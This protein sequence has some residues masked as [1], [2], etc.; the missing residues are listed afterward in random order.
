ME[1]GLG[2]GESLTLPH[3]P[4]KGRVKKQGPEPMYWG[5]RVV[6]ELCCGMCR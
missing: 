4:P 3:T 6:G 1:R 5:L 2:Q